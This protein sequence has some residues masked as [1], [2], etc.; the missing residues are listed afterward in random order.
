[1]VGAS[2]RPD[3]RHDHVVVELDDGRLLT[4][5]DPRRFGRLAILEAEAVARETG[6]GLD[7]LAA[8]FTP[9]AVFA[10]TRARR[11]SIKALLMDQRRV[12]GPGANSRHQD[13][14]SGRDPPPPRAPR[15]P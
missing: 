1:G 6:E 12:A 5:N 14:F 10:L 11:T 3:E 2:D 8:T 9:A 15:P 13:P 4:Y 7:P